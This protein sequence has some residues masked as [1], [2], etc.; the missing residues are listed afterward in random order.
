MFG[1]FKL[2]LEF[3]NCVT[4]VLNYRLSLKRFLTLMIIILGYRGRVLSISIELSS[5]HIDTGHN[6]KVPRKGEWVPSISRFALPH[7]NVLKLV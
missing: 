5:Y 1:A 7:M 2:I 6:V 4:V 3:Y